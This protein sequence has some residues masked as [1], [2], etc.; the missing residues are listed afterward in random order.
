MAHTGKGQ[1]VNRTGLADCF[2]VA[3]P[4][5]DNWVRAGCPVVERGSRGVEW[6]FNTSEVAKWL[7][8]RAVEEATG[9][10]KVD[11]DELE[12]RQLAAK[13]ATAELE[14]AKAK[15]LVAPISD[16]ELAWSRAFAT[17]CANMRN[18]PGRVVSQLIGE[19]DERRF[20]D[21]LGQEI[22]AALAAAG[23]TDLLDDDEADEP[24][25]GAA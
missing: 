13:T 17:I 7:R 20:K 19:T 22:D 16:T 10:R 6:V 3:L 12:R 9:T 14:L 11:I 4:T 5:V 23:D 18:I 8:D 21:V 2:G 24:D 15:G 1:H 25:A